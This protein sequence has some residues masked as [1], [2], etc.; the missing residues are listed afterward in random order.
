[1][2]RIIDQ[3]NYRRVSEPFVNAEQANAAIELFY[4]EVRELRNKHRIADVLVV[5]CVNVSYAEGEGQAMSRSHHGDPL[6]AEALAAYAYGAEQAER[7]R[8]MNLLLKG[9]R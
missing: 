2:E 6:K 8:M 7:R 9:T 4:K 1:M 5:C 3:K